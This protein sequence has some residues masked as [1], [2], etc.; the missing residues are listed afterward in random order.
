[1]S[2]LV[3]INKENFVVNQ[4]EFNILPHEEFNN[5]QILESLGE[6][7]RIVS[8]LTE[9]S[10]LF[11]KSNLLVFNCSHGGYI[12]LKVSNYF[13]TIGVVDPS[14]H[15]WEQNTKEKNITSA[16][17][18]FDSILPYVFYLNSDVLDDV[19][20][21]VLPQILIYNSA[22]DFKKFYPNY[23]LYYLS[24]SKF[25]VLVNNDFVQKFN[26]RFRYYIKDDNLLD[27]DNLIHLA[28]IV[29]NAGDS[30]ESILK[31]NL[32][33]FDRWTILDTGSTDDTINVIKKV[34]QNKKGKLYQEQFINFKDSRNRCLDLAGKSCK[35]IIT[36]DDTYIIKENLRGFLETIRGDQ[37]GDSYSIYL[38][39]NDVEYGSNRIIKS[40]TNLR[41]I[42]KIHEV[43]SPLNNVNVIIPKHHANLLD[44]RSDYMEQRT[45]DRKQYDLD[46]LFS[47]LEEDPDDPRA[48]YYLGQTYNLLDDHENAYKYFLLRVNHPIQ[49]FIQEKID[50]CF[51]AGRLS[52]FMLNK[53][54]QES[55]EL[56]LRAYEMDKTRPDSLYFLGI[57]YYLE[58]NFGEAYPYMKE[59]F[60]VSYPLHCQYS[61]KPTL[62]FYFLPKFLVEISFFV[63]DYQ[64][65]LESA[66]LFLTSNK[67]DTVE[68][69]TIQCWKK[70]FEHLLT[71]KI[72]KLIEIPLKP[73]LCFIVNGGFEKWTGSDII[74]KGM[75]GS[76]TF[77]VEIAK[78]C[79]KQGYF[80]VIVFCNCNENEYYEGVQY[81]KLEQ[82]FSFIATNKIHSLIVS[83]YPEYLPACQELKVENVYFIA[84]DMIP[85]GEII[86]K[87][88]NLKG[89]F[90]LSEFHK[91]AFDSMFPALQN[92][93]KV[94][95]Y[96]IDIDLF[97][98]STP[99]TPLKFIYSSFVNRGLLQLLEMWEKIHSKYSHA[100]LYIHCDIEHKWIK[101]ILPD[102]VDKIKALLNKLN[103]HNIHYLGWT[104]KSELAKT[105][106]TADI[107]LYPCTFDET[108]CLTALESAISKTLVIS[109]KRGALLN[110]VGDRG[111]L[112]EG[113]PSTEIWQDKALFM[114]S[115]CVE[116]KTMKSALLESN[117]KWA[118]ELSWKNRAMELIRILEPSILI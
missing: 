43:I 27:Y 44:F 114:I 64:L 98:C 75:G 41:Y 118:K 76:E 22:V 56:Y 23:Q 62:S 113:D 112:I 60:K 20:L 46:I 51:E 89:I 102:E 45:M 117:Y 86:I 36:L 82:C 95:G 17:D 35:F 93:T 58:D 57:H 116:N 61:L 80:D 5:L 106:Q 105:W 59:A 74:Q 21:Y 99:K 104:S 18:V 26:H 39:S 16:K 90:L 52:N 109:S 28:M 6:Q 85:N 68:Y 32:D 97:D 8:L 87:N 14:D 31:Q 91:N 70:I 7:E 29:K 69:Y 73:I 42:H 34:L 1:M 3:S 47:E 38:Q 50:A 33:Y 53:P 92:L 9:I 72:E 11:D 77:I 108:F 110:T 13:D 48:L 40:A 96:G 55:K 30:F 65:G 15:N 24:K 19:H 94:F 66:D 111:I 54:W 63:K 88:N 79:Q 100:S 81:K 78:Y 103:N 12:P 84:H 2:K 115:Q 25:I 4:N 67:N 37:F 101:S 10:Y 71:I 107:M 49:G 83:R